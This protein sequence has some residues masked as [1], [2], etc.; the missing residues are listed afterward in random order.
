MISQLMGHTPDGQPVHITPVAGWSGRI[1]I[2]VEIGRS[3]SFIL[4][5]LDP[6]FIPALKRSLM[7]VVGEAA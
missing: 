5:H 3:N 4:D 7:K 6:E 2:L 1:E